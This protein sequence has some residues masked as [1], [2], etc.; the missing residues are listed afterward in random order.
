[1]PARTRD[2]ETVRTRFSR[3]REGERGG[4]TGGRDAVP[5]GRQV[6]PVAQVLVELA[7]VVVAREL[8]DAAPH[9][10]DGHLALRADLLDGLGKLARALGVAVG[11]ARGRARGEL[12]VAGA[13]VD[14]RG[15]EEDQLRR[16]R[17]PGRRGEAQHVEDRVEVGLEALERHLRRV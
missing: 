7:A 5:L 9:I 4:R 8:H 11:D 3:A 15:R 12:G 2:R 1:M 14:G 17:V 16:G 13:V 10:D 6:Q